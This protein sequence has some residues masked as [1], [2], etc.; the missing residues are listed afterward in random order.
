MQVFGRK[1]IA[2]LRFLYNAMYISKLLFTEMCG[3]QRKS[4]K[5]IAPSVCHEGDA[6]REVIQWLAYPLNDFFLICHQR[7]VRDSRAPSGY[8]AHLE[9]PNA[10][11]R[12]PVQS[13]RSSN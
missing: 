6:K 3:C 4:G 2:V 7:K 13:F 12:H 1:K 8:A 10:C 5:R 9:N 11:R